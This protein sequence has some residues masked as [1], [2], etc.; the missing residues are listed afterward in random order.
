MSEKIEAFWEALGALTFA[1]TVT[2][3]ETMRDAWESVT[4]FECTD[5]TGWSF[6]LNTAR[7][8]AEDRSED[9]TT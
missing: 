9:E 1:E 7:E 4:D 2:I 5:V 8:I 6:L 3:A